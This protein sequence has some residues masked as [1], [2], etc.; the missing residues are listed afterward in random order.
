MTII[1]LIL[2]FIIGYCVGSIPFGY[3]IGR[4]KKIDIRHFGSGNIGATNVYRKL[5]LWPAILAGSLDFLKS[6]FVVLV[7]FS[8]NNISLSSKLILSISP[9][10]GHIFPI[11]LKFKGGKGVATI[12]GLLTAIFGWKFIFLWLIIWLIL[13]LTTHLMSLINLLMS[14]VLP[15]IFWLQF[16]TMSALIFSFCLIFIILWTHRQNIKR[17]LK[18]TENKIYFYKLNKI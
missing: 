16:Q 2:F 3:L 11:W 18:G 14:L 1:F 13:L 6:Y 5:G 15:I 4:V 7:F 17:L 8:L 10:I 12:F 9:I